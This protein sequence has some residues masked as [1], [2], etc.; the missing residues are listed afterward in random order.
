MHEN[1]KKDIV[2]NIFKT[3]VTSMFKGDYVSSRA[4]YSD[5]SFVYKVFKQSKIVDQFEMFLK[6][7]KGDLKLLDV[8]KDDSSTIFK[9]NKL[10][11]QTVDR[12]MKENK[13]ILRAL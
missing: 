3:N 8:F 12:L 10:Q 5:D 1:Y 13:T 9:F 6:N 7:Y 2:E 4:V 11:G